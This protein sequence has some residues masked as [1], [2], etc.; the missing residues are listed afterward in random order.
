[1]RGYMSSVVAASAAAPLLHPLYLHRHLRRRSPPTHQRN[2]C[3]PLAAILRRVAR[4]LERA[5]LRPW[6]ELRLP[7]H[8]CVEYEH[9]APYRRKDSESASPTVSCAAVAEEGCCMS[10][11]LFIFPCSFPSAP[12]SIVPAPGSQSCPSARAHRWVM[13]GC[14]PTPYCHLA[15]ASTDGRSLVARPGDAWGKGATMS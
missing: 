15:S 8:R 10:P 2:N 5:W 14:K 4:E 3:V 9:L 13:S 1:M 7:A 11:C 12:P 6:R